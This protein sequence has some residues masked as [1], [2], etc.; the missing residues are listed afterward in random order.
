MLTFCSDVP[1]NISKTPKLFP[2]QRIRIE[3]DVQDKV[4]LNFNF[5]N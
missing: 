4:V 1:K 2:I 3:I 5:I